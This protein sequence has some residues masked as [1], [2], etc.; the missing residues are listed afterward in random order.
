MEADCYDRFMSKYLAIYNG[1][2]T[3]G[4]KNDMS[5]ADQQPS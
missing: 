4:Q 2:A 3:D 1:A 5:F